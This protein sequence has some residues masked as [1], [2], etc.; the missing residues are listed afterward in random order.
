MPIFNQAHDTPLDG[1]QFDK[2]FKDGEEYMIGKLAMKVMWVPGHTPA[3]T[4][5]VCAKE[6]IAF[7]GDTIFNPAMGNARCDFPGG[8]ARTLFESARKLLALPEETVLLVGH[9]Y[10]EEGEPVC[11]G[12]TVK[13]HKDKNCTLNVRVTQEEFVAANSEKL[14]VPRLLLPSLQANIRAG[15]FGA[16]ESNGKQYIK[17]PINCSAKELGRC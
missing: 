7:V 8:S 15:S 11:T 2:L 13:Q 1:T 10:P 16:P 14:P 3:C 4:A 6:A 9:D 5:H 12:V 17:L